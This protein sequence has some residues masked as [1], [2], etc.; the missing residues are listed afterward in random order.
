MAAPRGISKKG[1]ISGGPVSSGTLSDLLT[2]RHDS[3]ISTAERLARIRLIRSENVG[4]TT[5]EALIARFGSGEKALA[6]LPDLARRGGRSRPIRIPPAHTIE[7]EI[8][9]AEKL[10]ARFLVLGEAGYPAR[11]AALSPPPPVLCLRGEADILSAPSIAIVGARNASALG[12]Q[13]AE[14]LARDLGQAGYPV[15][16]GLARGIDGAAHRGAL[17][18]GTIAVLAGGLDVI[19]PP[20]HEDLA[21]ALVRTGALLSEMPMGTAPQAS[22]FPRRNRLVAGLALGVVVVEAAVRSGSLIT[23]NH[24][25]EQGREVMAVP[26]FPLD[27]RARGCNHLLRQGATLVECAEDVVEAIGITA[28]SRTMAPQETRF[29][30]PPSAITVA[31]DEREE[32][33]EDTVEAARRALWPLLGAS[34]TPIDRL[35][36]DAG[37]PTE[38]ALTVLMEWDLAGRI[39]REPGGSVTARSASTD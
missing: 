29:Q 34:P 28:H 11:L 38:L 2:P 18:T 10:G 36:Q 6:A 9:A 5:F 30:D 4:P 22:L 26:G 15:V 25:A 39:H 31:P 33:P 35:I 37:V 14:R 32:P 24:A 12:R 1:P 13:F 16:S 23:A 20:E 7:R 19:Y 27:P 21:A 17:E 8:E 3:V